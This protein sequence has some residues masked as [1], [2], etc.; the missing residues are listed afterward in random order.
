MARQGVQLQDGL[1]LTL[2]MDDADDKGRP[3]ELLADGVVHFNESERRWVAAIDWSAI[4]H[5]SQEKSPEANESHHSEP[6]LQHG[7]HLTKG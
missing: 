5:A 2:Y 3:D 7:G 1:V 4:R 6:P